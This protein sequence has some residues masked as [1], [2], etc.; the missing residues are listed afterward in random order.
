MKETSDRDKRQILGFISMGMSIFNLGKIQQLDYELGTFEEKTQM[1]S[2]T[3][4]MF[5]KK[6]IKP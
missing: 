5:S 3:L 2:D 4:P 1:V 6:K